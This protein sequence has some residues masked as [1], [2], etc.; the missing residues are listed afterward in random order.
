[1]IVDNRPSRPVSALTPKEHPSM[2]FEPRFAF[3]FQDQR[4]KLYLLPG[5]DY[6]G[7]I[8][9]VTGDTTSAPLQAAYAS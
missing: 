3:D 1:M 9:R 4:T 6:L 2:G 8:G 7:H 5:P